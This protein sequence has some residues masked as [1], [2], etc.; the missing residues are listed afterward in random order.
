MP[1]TPSNCIKFSNICVLFEFLQISIFVCFQIYSICSRPPKIVWGRPESFRS[2]RGVISYN[3]N[4]CS[5][6]DTS[7]RICLA[8]QQLRHFG[9]LIYTL[10]QYCSMAL[11]LKLFS[12]P[13]SETHSENLV[14]CHKVNKNHHLDANIMPAL[15]TVQLRP[16]LNGRI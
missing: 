9:S 4:S 3:D 7:T 13:H 6:H 14:L 12:I 11:H 16:K 8:S 5:Q 15:I 10:R 1:K 2:T